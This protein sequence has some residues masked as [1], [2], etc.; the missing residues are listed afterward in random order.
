MSSISTLME[1]SSSAAVL[2][3]FFMAH[4]SPRARL[5]SMREGEPTSLGKCIPAQIR[6]F[7]MIRHVLG[8]ALLAAAIIAPLS[9]SA[10][11]LP[12]G[13]ERGAGEGERAAGPVGAI[14]GGTIGVVGGVAGVLGVDQRPR[15]RSYVV[16]QR[17]TVI[18]RAT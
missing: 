4:V 8:A 14:V 17:P 6:R 3:G 15:F 11:G 10:Q 13:V 16:E 9:A 5:Y 7:K 1:A 2:L 12:G 18:I